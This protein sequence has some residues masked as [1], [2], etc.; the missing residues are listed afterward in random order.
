V[1]GERDPE[2]LRADL[3]ARRE[4]GEFVFVTT[5]SDRD[6]LRPVATIRERQGL[7]MVLDRDTADRAGLSYDFVAAWLT[8]EV[9]S[10]LNAVGLTATV[11]TRLAEAGIA[12]NV[13]AGYHH[14]H[15]FVAVERADDAVALLAAPS[16]P[17]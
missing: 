16:R 5:G 1:P 13:I 10:A 15:L 6:D 2:R 11:S 14:D 17:G 7:T 3:S 12:C 8:L 9:H 4:P